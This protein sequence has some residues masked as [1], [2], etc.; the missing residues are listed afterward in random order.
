[1]Q[2][3]MRAEARAMD[4]REEREKDAGRKRR[5]GSS[6]GSSGGNC[7]VNKKPDEGAPQVQ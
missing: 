6:G 2:I 4:E 1:M 5:R 7:Y 3:V